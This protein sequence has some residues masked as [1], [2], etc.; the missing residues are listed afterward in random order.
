[1]V[2]KTSDGKVYDTEKIE[3]SS[4]LNTLSMIVLGVGR[5]QP[6]ILVFERQ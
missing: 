6:N 4:D 3:L 1:M 5:A 2:D